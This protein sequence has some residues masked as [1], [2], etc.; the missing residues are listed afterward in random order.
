MKLFWAREG[1]GDN[2]AALEAGVTQHT[3]DRRVK[4]I[5]LPVDLDSPASRLAPEYSCGTSEPERP[6]GR[7][8]AGI[9]QLILDGG[10]LLGEE[11]KGWRNGAHWEGL[12]L[13]KGAGG[14]KGR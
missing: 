9:A 8:Q 10:A 4:D 1:W 11:S 6:G 12:A 5:V 3:C 7:C 14:G 2:V 13:R